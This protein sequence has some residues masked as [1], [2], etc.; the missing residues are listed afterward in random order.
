MS[1]LADAPE[2]IRAL[3]AYWTSLAGGDPPERAAV[4]LEQIKPLLPHLMIVEFEPE[5]FTVRYRL[6]GTKI[7]EWSGFNLAG[8][9]LN[10]FIETDETGS[11]AHILECYERSWRTG[12]S[13]VGA[14]DWP[15]RSGNILRVWFCIYPLMVGGVIGQALSMEDYTEWPPIHDGVPWIFTKR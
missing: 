12:E 5:P 9:T 6:S 13:Y 8:R 14:Y 4:D 1:D 15:S 3:D 7:D 10:E 2:K 11:S